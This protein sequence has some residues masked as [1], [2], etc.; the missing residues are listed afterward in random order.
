VWFADRVG[1]SGKVYAN[2]IDKD[3]VDHL[4]ERCQQY[5]INNIELIL[6]EV[7]DPLLPEGTLDIAFMVNV[8]HHLERPVPL[9]RNIIPALKQEGILAIVER[10][11]AKVSNS[12]SHA[13]AKS[14]LIR[15][16]EEAGFEFV[17]LD[18]FMEECNLYIFQ[19]KNH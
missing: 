10:D 5:D 13:T 16:V 7:E 4:K 6:G 15:E 14:T 17:R 12:F 9:V 11:P 1:E 19:L 8:Y 2:D 3:A 18:D